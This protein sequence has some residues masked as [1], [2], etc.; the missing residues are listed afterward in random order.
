MA[1]P[2]LSGLD[3]SNERGATG[4]SLQARL[5]EC[6]TGMNGDTT[7]R[8]AVRLTFIEDDPNSVLIYMSTYFAV[9]PYDRDEWNVRRYVSRQDQF[10]IDRIKQFLEDEKRTLPIDTPLDGIDNYY[11][12]NSIF[13]NTTLAA[14]SKPDLV[15]IAN[16]YGATAYLTWESKKVHV[17]FLKNADHL[18][19][20]S[21]KSGKAWVDNGRNRNPTPNW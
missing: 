13:S 2:N 20:E 3:F 7:D 9:G 12:A 11:R 8:I 10:V 4:L 14:K 5:R 6:S 21:A 18:I 17:T 1:L 16:D 19:S 15:R